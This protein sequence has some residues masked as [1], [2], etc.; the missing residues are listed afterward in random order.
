M[1]ETGPGTPQCGTIQSVLLDRDEHGN[2]WTFAIYDTAGH[3]DGL[4]V[5]LSLDHSLAE[6]TDALSALVAQHWNQPLPGPWRQRSES[7][8]K[9]GTG[10]G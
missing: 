9:A 4:L 10:P 1:H 8:W 2:R 6:A 3:T 7:S 5:G